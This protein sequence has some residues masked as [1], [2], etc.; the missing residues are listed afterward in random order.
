MWDDPFN[1][2]EAVA[3]L[4]TLR[5]FASSFQSKLV[6][7]SYSPNAFSWVTFSGL[8]PWRFTFY[9]E[10][11]KMLSSLMEVVFR[12]VGWLAN[13]FADSLVKQ[14]MERS[15]PFVAFTLELFFYINI[16]FSPPVVWCGHNG[17]IPTLFP[18]HVV[19]G[20]VLVL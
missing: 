11:I 16:Y 20:W 17:F 6:V 19:F 18:F 1:E 8:T 10:G 15:S 9:L 5:L 7:E 12:H 3:I 13:G 4:E 2:E 14:G